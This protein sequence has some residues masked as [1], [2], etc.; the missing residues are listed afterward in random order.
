MQKLGIQGDARQYPV[1]AR[2]RHLR[3]DECMFILH[4]SHWTVLICKK[5]RLLYF[6]PAGN[7]PSACIEGHMPHVHDMNVQ[8][9]PQGSVLCG[10]YCIF[11]ADCM[12][13]HLEINTDR[14]NV[15]HM[16]RELLGRFLYF[17]PAPTNPN[18]MLMT[19]YTFHKEIGE[20][21]GGDQSVRYPK[22]NEYRKYFFT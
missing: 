1:K 14:T 5:G 9:Q 17:N 11:F 8:C 4:Q 19:L 7:P 2:L 18:C 12:I 21:F 15:I 16:A 6:D 10:N 20:E 3:E 22:F 13:N